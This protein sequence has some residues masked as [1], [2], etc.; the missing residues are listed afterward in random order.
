[1]YEVKCWSVKNSHIQKIKVEEMRMLRRMCGHTMRYRIRNKDIR[2]KVGVA[3][4]VDKTRKVRLRWFGHVKRKCV[5]APVR[6]CERLAIVG[7]RRGKGRP[8][9]Y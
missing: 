6:R 1:M 3:S 7:M 9:K 4:M 2:D 8:K 5:D